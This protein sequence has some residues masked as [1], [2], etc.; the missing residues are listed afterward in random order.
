MTYFLLR[1]YNILPKKELHSSLWVA[2]NYGPLA[3]QVLFLYTGL[4]LFQTATATWVQ[5]V[6]TGQG[7]GSSEGLVGASIM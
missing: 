1:D 3:L 5:G 2:D 7:G 6:V 4:A